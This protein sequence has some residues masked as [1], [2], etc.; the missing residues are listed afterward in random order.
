MAPQFIES[1]LRSSP[2]IKDAWVLAGPQGAYVAAV[3]VINYDNVSRWA[4]KNRVA[5]TSF[6]ELSQAPE[7][8]ELIRQDIAKV[9][10]TVPAESR[11]KKYINLHKE[12]DPDEGELTRTR[13]LRRAFLIKRYSKLIDAIYSDDEAVSIEAQD[14]YS[15]GRTGLMETSLRIQS[16]EGAG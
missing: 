8:Y 9:N 15:D 14:G 12:L 4:G 13:H 2:H 6:A 11:V 5:F 16:A 10:Q 3:I 7:V 1:R